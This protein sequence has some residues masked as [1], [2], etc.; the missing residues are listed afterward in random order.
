M[1]NPTDTYDW[2]DGLDCAVTVCDAEARIIYQNRKAVAQY[3]SHGN[4][5]GEN[6]MDCHNERSQ[7]IIRNILA[8]GCS[9]SYTINK[10][11]RDKFIHQAPWFNTDGSVGG[12]VEIST[13]IPDLPLP[14]YQR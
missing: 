3:A 2:A 5:I 6:L 1:V 14:H 8:I 9:N 7:A 12:I 10:N 13:F 11:G 4:L